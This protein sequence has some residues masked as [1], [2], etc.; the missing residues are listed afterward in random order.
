MK[1]L[2]F[3]SETGG[4][5]SIIYENRTFL[6]LKYALLLILLLHF[7][8]ELVHISLDAVVVHV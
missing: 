8:D 7:H 5:F 2:P 1:K 6:S 4:D 3:S